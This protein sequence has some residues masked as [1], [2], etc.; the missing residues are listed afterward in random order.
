MFDF[1]YDSIDTLKKLKVPTWTEILQIG[2]LVIFVVVVA[3]IIL[4][5]MDQIFAELYKE[6]YRSFKG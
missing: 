5:F 3:A 2:G 4:G 6:I 1:F